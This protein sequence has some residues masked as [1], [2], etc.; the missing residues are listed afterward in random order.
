MAK[1]IILCGF[2]SCGKTTVGKKL[3]D[4]IGYKFIDT[5]EMIIELS[6]KSIKELFAEG[7]E[8]LFRDMEHEVAK[9]LD[10]LEG[11]VISTGGGMMTFDRNIDV[12]NNG[13][14]IYIDTPFNICYKRLLGTGRP[15]VSSKTRDE[16]IKM[17]NERISMYKKASHYKV[18]NN[19]KPNETAKEI[20]EV[21]SL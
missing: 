2:M 14:V 1:N 8:E 7:G 10:S 13:I 4:L 18:K 11:Y 20:M 15:I 17:Y 19:N 5:D 6:G 3:A 9:K 21:M 16:M 12:I